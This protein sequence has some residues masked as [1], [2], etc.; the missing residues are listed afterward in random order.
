[1]ADE[2]GEYSVMI[3]PRTRSA[4]IF[5]FAVA[6]ALLNGV[7]T[8]AVSAKSQVIVRELRSQ[9]IAHTKVGTDP[10]RK[11]LVYLPAGYDESS[12]QRYP[13]IYFLPNPFEDSYRFH[14]DHRDAQGLFDRA[15]AERVIEKF[16]LVAV[17]MNTNE[18]PTRNFVVRQLFSDWKLGRLHDPGARAVHRRK[19]QNPT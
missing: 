7:P 14:F 12:S 19:F 13:V 17:D 10:V 5:T 9:N 1:M 11:M 4:L 15:I 2:R 3:W 6:L 16:I 8:F 18:Y